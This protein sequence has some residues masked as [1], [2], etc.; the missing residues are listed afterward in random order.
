MKNI[1]LIAACGV[2][3]ASLAG[4]LKEKGIRV[5]GSDANVYPPMST[6][7][8]SLGIGL[9]SPYA[10]G[11]IP[12]DADLIVVGNAVSRDNPEAQEA[13]RLGLPILSFPQAVAE[14]FLA[15]KESIVVAGTH[16]K[17]NPTSPLSFSLFYLGGGPPFL[18]G[19]GAGCF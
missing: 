18:V 12:E 7:L 4:M 14:Y 16:R 13:V 19:G 5:T 1:H 8:A 9:F 11:N 15:G 6:Q 3:M 17:T 10:A 2:G